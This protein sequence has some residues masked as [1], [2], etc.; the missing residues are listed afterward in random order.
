VI[1][2]TRQHFG[3]TQERLAQWLGVARSTIAGAENGHRSW[4]VG[5]G[6]QNMRLSA[7]ALGF[8]A[9]PAGGLA[10]LLPAL[11]PPP[12]EEEEFRQRSRYCVY[13]IQT[14][15]FELENMQARAQQL[16]ARLA[17]LP[18]LRAWTGPVPHAER[19]AR[20][21]RMF[22]VEAV[23]G[24]RDNC[25]QGPQRLL[26]ARI[27]GLERELELLQELLSAGPTPE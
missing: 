27:G 18:T 17:A 7:A 9:D 26:E 4:P 25:G 24:L 14:L 8:A 11:P 20:W 1:D 6:L 2:D 3:L 16:E 13:Q 22:E 23:E 12:I 21:L 5:K 19:E 15:R 10:P